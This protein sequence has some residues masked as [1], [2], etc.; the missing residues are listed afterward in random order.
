MELQSLLLAE[1]PQFLQLRSVRRGI[2]FRRR[3][4]H[5]LLQ[6]LFAERAQLAL[7]NLK[8]FHWIHLGHVAGINQVNQQPRPLHVPQKAN[9][10]SRALARAFDQSRQIRHHECAAQLRSV[11]ARAAVGIHHAQIRFQRRKRIIRNLRPRRANHRNQRG[12]PRIRKTHQAHV[13]QQL[14]LQPQIPLFPGLAFLFL[15][16]RLVPRL[17]KMLIAAPAPSALRHQQTL[18]WPFQIR[19]QYISSRIKNQRAHRHFQ[20]RVVA[21]NPR[22]VRA[23]PVPSAVRLELPVV[24]VT[25]QRVVVRIRFQVNAPAAPAIAAR[26]PSARHILLPPKRH[27]PVPAI[28]GLHGNFRFINKHSLLFSVL[29]VRS[30]CPLPALSEVEGC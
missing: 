10:Q 18:P 24:A 1:F 20:N 25:Q 16:R 30:L 19:Q 27:A 13:R 28:P 9:A 3:H 7:D 21:R 8:R 12:L 6:Q 29:S 17:R 14:Q 2:Q 15:S 22:T 11:P 5:R 23:F 26:R 4:D